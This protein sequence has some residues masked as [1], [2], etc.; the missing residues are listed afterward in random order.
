MIG[1]LPRRGLLFLTI[2]SVVTA[3]TVPSISALG[4]APPKYTPSQIASL[5][6]KART[7]E[8]AALKALDTGDLAGVKAD[9]EASMAK[10][11][12][13]RQSSALTPGF[14]DVTSYL[15]NA[16]STDDAALNGLP[17]P[18]ERGRVRRL[19]NT[20]IV[21]KDSA[22]AALTAHRIAANRAPRLQPMLGA[23]SSDA[24]ATT[25]TVAATDP[26]GDKLTYSWV[27]DPPA[28]DPNCDNLGHLI[29][30]QRTFV[31]H[32]GDS[33]AS[34][35]CDHSVEDARGHQGTVYVHVSD[36]VWRCTAVYDGTVSGAGPRP[37]PCVRIRH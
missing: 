12:A 24:K 10:L 16:L 27:L 17:H 30:R 2:F 34:G 22:L 7:A 14:G 20:A 36:G 25:Y 31:W 23:F 35:D 28:N 1:G 15:K 19:I 6:K 9:L 13:A 29:S 5:V 37:E 3:L 32:H 33:V 18:A 26:D 21:R 8:L 4:V 11:N